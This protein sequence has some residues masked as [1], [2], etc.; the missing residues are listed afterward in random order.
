VRYLMTRNTYG[1]ESDSEDDG[2]PDS[3][4]GLQYDCP[5]FKGLSMY[6][7]LMVGATLACANYLLY[8]PAHTSN[9]AINWTGGRHHAKRAKCSGFCYVNDVVLGIQRLRTKFQKVLYIDLDLHHG[10]G[11]ETAF[12]HSQHVFCVSVH[13]FEPGFF[14]GSGGLDN[15]RAKHTVNIPTK[16]WLS[17]EVLNRMFEDIICPHKE[18]FLP[19]AVVVTCGCDG[20]WRDRRYG[21]WNL[22][23]DGID[24]VV[25]QILSWNLPTLLLGGGGYHL[26][27][28]ARCWTLLTASALGIESR[29]EWNEIPDHQ[30]VDE[31]ADDLCRL[32]TSSQVGM[33]ADENDSKYVDMLVDALAP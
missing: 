32:R 1:I 24:V 7:R 29:R 20:L 14:P 6:V 13:R 8:A 16:R 21:E 12:A 22:S 18:R 3:D 27:D 25:S 33:M 17:D 19:D 23:I 4:Y 5:I 28:S 9:V 31:Y 15:R 30:F 2:D 11:V 10:D 26:T